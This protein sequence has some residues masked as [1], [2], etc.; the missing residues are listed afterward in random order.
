MDERI[1][2]L[3]E[4]TESTFDTKPKETG[5]GENTPEEDAA[6]SPEASVEKEDLN[7]AVVSEAITAVAEGKRVVFTYNEHYGCYVVFE[8]N[9]RVI[10]QD[11]ELED[12][13]HDMDNEGSSMDAYITRMRQAIETVKEAGVAVPEGNIEEFGGMNEIAKATMDTLGVQAYINAYEKLTPEEQEKYREKYRTP[14]PDA[15]QNV[16]RALQ[17][18]LGNV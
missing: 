18:G 16:K 12:Y 6:V 14:I 11:G 7:T 3:E 15:T 8:P 4:P 9:G 10:V 5:L 13:D 2:T 1:H 17:T